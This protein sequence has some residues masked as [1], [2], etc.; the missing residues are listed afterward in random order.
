M[1]GKYHVTYKIEPHPEGLT[2]EQIPADGS[3]GACDCI[4]LYSVIG[5]PGDG[6][7]LSAVIATLNGTNGEPLTPEQQFQLW[8]LWAH[9]LMQKLPPGGRRDLASVVHNAI[10][11]AAIKDRD[12]PEQ[13]E[14]AA[15]QHA[16]GTVFT[17]PRPGRHH[18]VIAVMK[19]AGK[20]FN[21]QRFEYRHVQGFVTSTG[22][23]VDRY[24]AKVIARERH[25]LLE[26]ASLSDELF[27]EDVW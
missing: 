11:H 7:G 22:R 9:E 26:R 16:D 8:T 10:R 15:I 1:D 24:E 19:A 5:V 12:L 20:P 14:M 2:R 3:V 17:V 21:E 13:I 23:F 6:K 18:D 4:V 27:S 25:Q